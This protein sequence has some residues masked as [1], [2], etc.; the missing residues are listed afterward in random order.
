M[1]KWLLCLAA[2]APWVAAAQSDNDRYREVTASAAAVAPDL[3]FPDAVADLSSAAQ[4]RMAIYK[5]AGDGPFPGLVLLP[6]CS[7]L[8]PDDVEWARWGVARGYVVFVVDAM[9]G[10]RGPVCTPMARSN[11]FRGTK[12]AFQALAHLKKFPFVDGE[13]V[14][15]IG[16]SWGAMVALKAN[17]PTSADVFG[18]QDRYAASVGLYPICH[19]APSMYNRRPFDFVRPDHDRPMLVLMGEADN[20]APPADCVPRLQALVDRG[21]AV[22]WHVYPK[23][24]HCWD[25]SSMNGLSKVDFRGNRVVYRYDRDVT[26][27]S[28]RR[29]FEFLDR[30][31]NRR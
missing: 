2:W 14:G 27:D 6:N 8:R 18:A 22:E 28:A 4:A 13:R 16:F 19:L 17:S 3:T 30:F 7:G 31:L 26:E 1:W 21:V 5:P 15:L 24:T 23:T 12:D 25:C 10:R 20:E 9:T 11:T 29:A